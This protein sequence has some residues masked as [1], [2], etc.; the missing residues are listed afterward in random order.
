[1]YILVLT[2]CTSIYYI[3]KLCIK[4]NYM[5]SAN[6]Y[7]ST[8]WLTGNSFWSVTSL[9]AALND[10]HTIVYRKYGSLS[11]GHQK[12]AKQKLKYPVNYC[13]CS[14]TSIF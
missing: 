6:S 3:N 10:I 14:S 13:I 11:H 2:H 7:S 9:L 5:F 12:V 4:Y 1:M 8:Y